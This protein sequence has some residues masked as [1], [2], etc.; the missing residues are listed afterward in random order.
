MLL[1][2]D[3]ESKLIQKNLFV[4][5]EIINKSFSLQEQ[6]EQKQLQYC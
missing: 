6:E 5:L 4:K 1:T 2:K 3:I